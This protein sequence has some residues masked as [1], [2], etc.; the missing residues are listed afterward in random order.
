MTGK[1]KN[2]LKGKLDQ[3]MA[4]IKQLRACVRYLDTETQMLEADRCCRSSPFLPSVAPASPF[5]SVR[6]FSL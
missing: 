4:Y 1:N 3:C 5:S 6:C 2:D